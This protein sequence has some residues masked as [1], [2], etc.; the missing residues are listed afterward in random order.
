M[1]RANLN[2]SEEISSAFLKAQE[3]STTRALVVG[4]TGEELILRQIVDKTGDTNEDFNYLKE[5]ALEL[6]F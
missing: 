1:A 6:S 3:S 5:S 4:I 2:V